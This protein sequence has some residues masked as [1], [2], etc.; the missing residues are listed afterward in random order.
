MQI[1]ERMLVALDL[2]N[3]DVQ[4]F[5]FAGFL[6]DF[7]GLEKIYF[8]HIVPNLEVPNSDTGLFYRINDPEHPVDEKITQ[9]IQQ[10][11]TDLFWHSG[12]VETEIEV[13]EGKPYQKLI[14][15]LDV[16]QIDLLLVGKKNL[17]EGSGITPQRIARKAKT[18]IFFAG[19]NSFATPEKVL[20]PLD[21]SQP[22]VRALKLALKLKAKDPSISIK[23]INVIST[24]TTAPEIGISYANLVFMLKENSAKSYRS[25]LEKEAIDPVLIDFHI[26]TF[27]STNIATC[28]SNYCEKEDFDLI[29]TGATGQS[30]LESFL[31]GSVTE[32]LVKLTSKASVLVVR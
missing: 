3:K 31:F 23:A 17:S 27:K 4:L 18:T 10:Q 25:L 14:H 22:S 2:S 20:V 24:A 16:K 7:F 32:S 15:W 29:I 21:F 9:H 5:D 1:Y 12:E 6:T 13:I 26:E 28:I 11:L 8:V 30:N 19:E